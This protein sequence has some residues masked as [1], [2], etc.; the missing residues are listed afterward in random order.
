MPE[1]RWTEEQ[2]ELAA[3]LDELLR[4][5]ADP[6][7]V[8]AACTAP[9]GYDERL[10]SLLSEQVGVAGLAVPEALGGAGFGFVEVAVAL[11][12]LGRSLAPS[13]LL[14]TAVAT[15]ALL[16]CAAEAAARLLP[17]L[18]AGAATATLA[19]S[20]TT[21]MPDAP[22]GVTAAGDALTGAVDHV[23][24]GDT[25][26]VLL[27]VATDDGGPALFAVEPGATGLARTH[28]PTMDPTLRLVRLVLEDT[29]ADRL[30]DATDLLP[31]VHAA[32]AAAVA[33]TATGVARRGL[34]MTVAYTQEREQFGR[35]IA[36]FQALKHRMADLLVLVETSR[37]ITLAAALAVAE[38][39]EAPRRTSAAKAWCDD[40]LEKVAA[41]TVQLH[42]GIAI[43]WEHDAH[44]VLKRAHALRQLFGPA[45]E[46][47]RA[48][49]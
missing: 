27:V 25:A 46:H 34:E 31:R 38:D 13:P 36:S 41:E 33:A 23:L 14:A 24:A 22:T 39:D 30:G 1:L 12:E 37:S 43:T 20:G 47:R 29:P 10:W 35:P 11:E 17:D 16:D 32:G 48:L 8:R 40:A 15:Q 5:H 2:Q 28:T 49:L 44:L 18:A 26:D 45:H 7:A 42:G 3:V 6:G 9:Q 21:G 19:W 4:R